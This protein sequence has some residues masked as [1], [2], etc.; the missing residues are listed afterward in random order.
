[1]NVGGKMRV[2]QNYENMRTIQE[3]ISLKGRTALVTGAAGGIGSATSYALAQLG[4]N[5]ALVDIS[6]QK[7]RL[8]ENAEEI[9]RRCNVECRCYLVD[10]SDEESVIRLFDQVWDELGPVTIMHN[11]AGIGIWPDDSSLPTESWKK[12]VDVN[13][14]GS[15]YMARTCA[16]KLARA[17]MKGSIVT[18]ASMSGHIINAGPGYSATKAG[19]K[20]MSASLGIEFA[21]QGIRFNT[22]SYGYILSGMH[23]SSS[24]EALE[25]LLSS[26]DEHTPMGRMG[27]LDEVVGAVIF[28]ATELSSF[29]TGSDVLV[30]GGFSIGRLF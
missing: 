1:M 17:G 4:A 14:S 28:C 15:F 19:V 9:R 30:D 25:N 18:T 23:K 21:K 5:I 8:Q 3:M 27:M 2:P 6:A 24:E 10:I 16:L 7:K 26:F 13:L 12:M 29:M 20:H 11:N 22:V